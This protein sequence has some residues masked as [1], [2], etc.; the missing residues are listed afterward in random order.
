MQFHTSRTSTSSVAQAQDW[1]IAGCA[2]PK[3][4]VVEDAMATKLSKYSHYIELLVLGI[5]LLVCCCS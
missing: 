2:L 3:G 1:K 5:L 4:S